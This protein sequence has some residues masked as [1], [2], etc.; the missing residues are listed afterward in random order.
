MACSSQLVWSPSVDSLE[1]SEG[2]E[3]DEG[4]LEGG[5]YLALTDRPLF[6]LSTKYD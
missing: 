2:V 4:D 3:G 6:S 1:E 5:R